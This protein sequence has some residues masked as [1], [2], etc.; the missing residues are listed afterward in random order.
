MYLPFIQNYI[1]AQV[2]KRMMSKIISNSV[3]WKM[4][5]KTYICNNNL[6]QSFQKIQ[7]MQFG[8]LDINITD[9]FPFEAEVLSSV[10]QIVR[11]VSR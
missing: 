6:G 3:F 1:Y 8:A 2:R 4:S 9:Y 5:S 10:H 11:T 7:V